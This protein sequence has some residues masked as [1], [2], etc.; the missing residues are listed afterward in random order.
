MSMAHTLSL[1][2]GI[3]KKAKPIDKK[4]ML[5][6]LP[7]E[8]KSFELHTMGTLIEILKDKNEKKNK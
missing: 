8:K 3:N 2:S 4:I 1:V 7:P 6:P 5:T